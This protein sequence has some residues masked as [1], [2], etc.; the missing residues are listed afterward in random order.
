MWERDTSTPSLFCFRFDIHLAP[1]DAEKNKLGDAVDRVI[2]AISESMRDIG[3][4]LHPEMEWQEWPSGV[5]LEKHP[6]LLV[7]RMR[8]RAWVHVREKETRRMEMML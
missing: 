1:E 2:E 5:I 4:L 7:Y 6:I 8:L 3:E